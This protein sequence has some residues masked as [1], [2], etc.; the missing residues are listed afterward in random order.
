MF[1][2]RKKWPGVTRP[3]YSAGRIIALIAAVVLVAG[4]GGG[5]SNSNG[6]RSDGAE[7]T[8]GGEGSTGGK[9]KGGADDELAWVPFGPADPEIPDPAWPAYRLLAEGDCS[10]LE[11]FLTGSSAGDFGRAMVAVC[12]A[13]VDGRQD[14]WQV[15][16]QALASAD[17]SPLIVDTDP[18]TVC[19]AAVIED[20]L[21]RALDWHKRNPG[22]QPSVR[23]PPV[24][25]KTECGKQQAG[26]TTPE[27]DESPE[28]EE[29]PE[30]EDSP[31][32]DE[33]PESEQ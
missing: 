20:L 9:S 17:P 5:S 27:E 6:E 25:D 28:T 32:T 13:A 12:A 2:R 10:G 14:Q 33:S 1:M 31:D 29:T 22:E 4:C 15:A 7:R 26:E 24:A 21:A 19:V 16:E 30:A 8:S 3:F 23:F 18:S 11:D